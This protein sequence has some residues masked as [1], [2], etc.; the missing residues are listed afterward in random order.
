MDPTYEF[1]LARRD[2]GVLVAETMYGLAG[3]GFTGFEYGAWE[4]GLVDG[5]GEVL[6]LKTN[7]VVGLVM[8]S[9]LAEVIHPVGC[10][11]LNTGFGSQYF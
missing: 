10:I 8:S 4:V 1:E 7:A 2:R 6:S 5:I 9:V 3:I 11:D